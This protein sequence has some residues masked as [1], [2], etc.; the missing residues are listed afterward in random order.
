MKRKLTAE[1]KKHGWEPAP[2]GK[3]YVADRI[4]TVTAARAIAR[5][6]AA[7]VRYATNN[8]D[9]SDEAWG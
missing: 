5:H 2:D 8:N 6:H 9:G 7:R 4:M 3:V 1:M